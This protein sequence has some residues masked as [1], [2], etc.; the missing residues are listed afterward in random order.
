MRY[1]S[2]INKIIAIILFVTFLAGCAPE[3]TGENSLS[4]AI[5]ATTTAAESATQNNF[6]VSPTQI[7]NEPPESSEPA[8]QPRQSVNSS[9]ATNTQEVSPEGLPPTATADTRPLP[10]DWQDWPVIPLNISYRAREIYQLGLKMGNDPNAFSVTGDIQAIRDVMLGEFDDP[11]KYDFK[12]SEVYLLEAVD[13]FQGSFN[14]DGIAV[15]DD[16]TAASV[17]SPIHADMEYCKPG[18]TPLG[19]EFRIHNP[20]ILIVSLEVWNDRTHLDRY[21]VYL[22]QILDFSI[23]RG[24]LPILATK[25]D[26]AEALKHVINPTLAQLAYEYDI[27]LW[28]FWLA[29]QSIPNH[30]IDPDRDGFYISEE[31]WHV[32]SFTALKS[33]HAVWRSVSQEPGEV[34]TLAPVIPTATET[35]IPSPT[36]FIITPTVVPTPA[37]LPICQSGTE[38]V[39]FGLRESIHGNLQG[40]GI[41]LIEIQTGEIIQIVED[42]FS[43]LDISPDGKSMLINRESDLYVSPMTGHNPELI[44]QDFFGYGGNGAYWMPDGGSIVMI[45]NRDGENAIWLYELSGAGWTRITSGDEHPIKLYPSVDTE[46]VYWEKGTCSARN[47]CELEGVWKSTLDGASTPME[48]VLEPAFSPD[49]VHVAFMDPIYSY[50]TQDDANDKLIIENLEEGI[51]S[52]RLIT[53]P[54]AAGFQ[55]RNRLESYH[56]SPTSDRIMIFLDERSKYYERM[57]GYHAY[58]FVLPYGVLYEFDQMVGVGPNVAWAQDSV[59]MLLALTRYTE[60]NEYEV[61]L[62]FMDTSNRTTRKFEPVED[63]VSAN[64]LYIDRMFWLPAQP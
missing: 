24:V 4:S 22:R 16:F 11:R 44:T 45:A 23:E 53:F 49:G 38:C 18:E 21:E 12:P 29:V 41:F 28:N 15:R 19:C 9:T 60:N 17:L 46:Q 43:L 25:A 3:K 26:M 27:P 58:I 20:S 37:V 59:R 54:A 51:L 52:R 57:A 5:S 6:P 8:N 33:L 39:L 35:A 42:G 1:I 55:V 10:E 32:K 47:E 2:N 40:K 34:A 7:N 36:P 30:G 31:A 61:Q 50:E 56:W 63:L 62:R 64:Y 13:Y 48:G 14:R